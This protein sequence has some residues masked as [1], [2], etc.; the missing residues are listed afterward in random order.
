ME[1]SFSRISYTRTERDW[2]DRVGKHYLQNA[3]PGCLFAVGV[4]GSSSDLF[5]DSVGEGE[6]K[7][8][9]LVSRPVA[10]KLPQDGSVG[11]ITRLVL[12]PECPYGTASDTIRYAFKVALA[13]KMQ[14]V[15]AYH[16]R[17]R[18]TGCV[19]KKAGMKKDTKTKARGDGPNAAWGTRAKRKSAEYDNTPKR[20][21][22][23]DW[24]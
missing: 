22:R 5:G 6:L 9:L 11:E 3:P 14:S 4:Y 23:I 16:D 2:L 12:L 19:Y 13:R 7:G 18:H 10:R 15:I 24:S 20:R 17:T 21:W 8:I 1:V